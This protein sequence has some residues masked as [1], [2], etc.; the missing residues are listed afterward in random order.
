MQKEERDFNTREI[1]WAGSIGE[2][3]RVMHLV[4]L[5]D[6]GKVLDVGTAQWKMESFFQTTL[7]LRLRKYNR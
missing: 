4:V 6:L 5:C 7:L 1:A 3:E 2:Y